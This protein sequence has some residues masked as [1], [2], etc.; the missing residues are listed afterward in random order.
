VGGSFVDLLKKL[1]VGDSL[2][3]VGND[4]FIFHTCGSVAVLKVAVSLLSKSFVRPHPHSSM[5]MGVARTIV[6]CLVVGREEPRQ[7][8]QE[9]MH[10][11]GRLSSHKS[12]VLP[13]T[14]GKYPAMW[15]SLPPEACV[16]MLYILSQILG[17]ERPSYF[18]MVV[19]K[20]LGYLIVPR[21]RE[22]T[23]KFLTTPRL[24]DRA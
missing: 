18:S 1:D 7:G 14:R 4:V 22:N 11:A 2:L 10:S 24:A 12:E 13:I 21:R 20:S 8:R 17:S 3:V 6:G 9:V 23:K 15:S 19:L 16:V 5:V